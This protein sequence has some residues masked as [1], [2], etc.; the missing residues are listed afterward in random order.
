MHRQFRVLIL[1]L[2]SMLSCPVLAAGFTCAQ[3]ASTVADSPKASQL[4][5]L[6]DVVVDGS[7]PTSR[8]RDLGAW[9]KRMEG[10]YRYEDHVDLCG[11]GNAA[12]Q[13]PVTGDADCFGLYVDSGDRFPRSLYC[14]VRVRWTR[15]LGENG[16]PVMGGDPDLLPAVLVYGVN[17]GLPG[18]QLMQIDSH[19][20]A[21]QALGTLTGDTLTTKGSCGTGTSCQKVARITARSDSTDIAMLIDFEIGSRRALRQA[22]LLHRVSNVRTMQEYWGNKSDSFAERLLSRAWV[23]LQSVGER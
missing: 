21:T 13:R 19:G 18:I 16:I 3:P 17:S 6:E 22:F 20:L 15:V 7:R 4:D 5:Q 10:Q 12:D 8:T 11:R 14:V 2:T 9:L 23:D 1:T